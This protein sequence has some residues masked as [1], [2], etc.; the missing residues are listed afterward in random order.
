MPRLGDVDDDDSL[1]EY[2]GHEPEGHTSHPVTA[3]AGLLPN[4]QTAA[5]ASGTK[6]RWSNYFELAGAPQ[7]DFP[8]QAPSP[9][10]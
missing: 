1:S 7:R 10:S 3:T 4:F 2:P 5:R 6:R 8:P 9:T